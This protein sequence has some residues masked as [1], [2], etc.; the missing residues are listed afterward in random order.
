MVKRPQGPS[1][2]LL[3]SATGVA[4]L[5]SAVGIVYL[6]L[7]RGPSSTARRPATVPAVPDAGSVP[8]PVDPRPAVAPAPAAADAS[9]SADGG[10]AGTTARPHPHHHDPAEARVLIDGAAVENPFDGTFLRS[11]ARR[12]GP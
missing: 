8:R 9:L 6:A 3:L 7:G 1:S 10:P 12:L 4:L 11:E 5:F 2:R